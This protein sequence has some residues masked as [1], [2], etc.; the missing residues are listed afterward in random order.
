M[1]TILKMM[2][3]AM[4]LFS[5]SNEQTEQLQTADAKANLNKGKKQRSVYLKAFRQDNQRTALNGRVVSEPVEYTG[6]LDYDDFIDWDNDGTN[7]EVVLVQR[8]YFPRTFVEVTVNG[9]PVG[10]AVSY[11]AKILGFKDVDGDGFK[12]IIFEGGN[13]WAYNDGEAYS[14]INVGYNVA[15]D[16]VPLK[17][18]VQSLVIDATDPNPEYIKWDLSA[19]GI[20]NFSFHVRLLGKTD[21][22]LLGSQTTTYGEWGYYS[23]NKLTQGETYILRFTNLGDDCSEIDVEFTL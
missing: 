11:Y 17:D 21:T 6:A 9:T 14:P 12:D 20:H 22:T 1:K 13:P 3:I 4:V 5:C 19:Y 2:L 15:G 10:Y 23:F 8:C 16:A 18:I 7:D